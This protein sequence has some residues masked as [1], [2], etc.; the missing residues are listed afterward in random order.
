MIETNNA[1]VSMTGILFALYSFA[2]YEGSSHIAEETIDAETATPKGMLYGVVARCV[3]R[4]FTILVVA[5]HPSVI[6]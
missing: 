6:Y 3:W 4:L 2:G 5:M 1:W